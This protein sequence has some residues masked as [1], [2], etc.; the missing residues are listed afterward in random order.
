MKGPCP[1][2]PHLLVERRRHSAG[3]AGGTHVRQGCTQRPQ[4][5]ARGDP[6]SPPGDRL[7]PQLSLSRWWWGWGWGCEPHAGTSVWRGCLLRG[8]SRGLLWGCL[9]DPS[10]APRAK[11]SAK[12]SVSQV[13][14]RGMQLLLTLRP[15][16]LHS[17]H[18]PAPGTSIPSGALGDPVCA[19]F[20][21]FCRWGDPGP[22]VKQLAR[23]PHLARP[24]SGRPTGLS[25][26]PT[27]DRQRGHTRVRGGR[28][29]EKP[30]EAAG[31][32]WA[33]SPGP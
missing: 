6:G 20:C 2:G 14:A 7:G 16:E 3:P 32:L 15:P 29:G 5:R 8:L 18:P 28:C 25:P 13:P 9:W 27:G 22:G 30:R 31:P 12:H 19:G 23:G 21:P 24:R 11:G 4:S 17:C 26:L 33:V 10:G 1:E